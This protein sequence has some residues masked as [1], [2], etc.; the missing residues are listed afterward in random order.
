MEENIIIVSDCRNLS[1]K[2][3]VI[4]Y[5]NQGESIVFEIIDTS[6]DQIQYLGCVDSYEVDNTNITFDYINSKTPKNLICSV[7][8]IQTMTIQK[9]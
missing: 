7:G 2:I 5:R 3:T 6:T 8:H 4:G 1:L 9:A